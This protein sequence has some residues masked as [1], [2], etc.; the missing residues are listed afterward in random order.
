M[1][2]PMTV[3]LSVYSEH[4]YKEFVLPATQNAVTT[5]T[6]R[7]DVF[8]LPR[9]VNLLLEN[10]DGIWSFSPDN[11]IQLS[12]EG[13]NAIGQSLRG[14]QY[15]S[16]S[17]QGR[18]ALAILVSIS[19]QH[20]LSYEKYTLTGQN[21]TIGTEERCGLQ[22]SFSSQNHQYISGCHAAISRQGNTLSILD[23]S[24]NG[25][26]VNDIRIKGE[27]QLQFG[28]RIDVWGLSMVA[29]GQVLAVRPNENLHV[30]PSQLTLSEEEKAPAPSDTA[31][32]LSY[33]RS[34]RSGGH[35]IEGSIDLEAPP[36]PQ[37][38][39]EQPL[40]MVIGPALTMA[41]PMLIGSGMAVIGAG[42]SSAFMYTGIVTAVLSAVIGAMWALINLRYSR[43]QT[44]NAEAHRFSAYSDYL[45]R[46]TEKIR[47][48]YEQN[49]AI[50]RQTYPPAIQCLTQGIDHLW[51][52]NI[53]HADYLRYRLGLGDQPFQVEIKVPAER[54]DLIEDSLKTKP[55]MIRE[56]FKTLHDVPVCIDLREERI[57]GL[58]GGPDR[59]GA[60]EVLYTLVSQIVAQNCYTD[61][62]LAFSYHEDQGNDVKNWA[63]CRW[64]P[65]AWS[66]DRKSRYVA[67]NKS[68]ASDMFYE[69]MSILRLRD[70][71]DHTNPN[72]LPQKP[73]YI[74]IIEDST[75]LEN[76]P[77]AKYLLD[78]KHDYGITTLFL[79]DRAEDLPN[80]CECVISNSNGSFVMYH[81]R[82]SQEEAGR[83]R[84]DLVSREELERFARSLANIEV[85][86]IEI[87]GEIPSAVTFFDMYGIE[88]LEEL[89]VAERWKRSRTYE[90]MRALIGQKS[91][92][93]PCYLDIHEKYH[94]PH[95][96]VAGTTGS[97]KS[98]T[99]QTYILSLTLNFSPYD[100][101]LFIIDYKGGGMANLFDGLPHML[102]QISNLSGNQVHRAMVSIKSENLRRQRIFNESGVNNINLYTTLYKNGEAKVPVPHLFIIIDEFAELKREQPDFMRELISVAQVGRSL[103]VH[104]ILATQKPS[105]TVDDNIWSNSKFRL[106]LRVQDRQDSMD[107]L[108]KPDAAYLTQAGRGFLQVGSDEVY[109]QFQSGWSGAAYDEDASGSKQVLARMLSNT[110]KTALV[111]NY[112]KR[113]RKEQRLTV[114]LD[115]L[116]GCLNEVWLA[117]P[118]LQ[119][120]QSE[121]ST[122][123]D[124][125]YERFAAQG[126]SYND[127]EYNRRLLGNFVRLARASKNQPQQASWISLHAT[128][129]RI[130]LPE[131]KEKT[132]LDA[133]VGYLAEQAKTLNYQPLPPL[134]LD[135]LPTTLA[136]EELENWQINTFQNGKWP[137]PPQKWELSASVGLGDDPANQSQLPVEINFRQG[138]NDGLLGA[139]GTGKSTFVQTLVYSL[140]HRYTPEYLNI[141][142][143]DFSNHA[144]AAFEGEAHI[145]GILSE[146][147]LDRVGK[148]FYLLRQM[149]AER[150]KAFQGG[151][152]AQYVMVH[153]PQYPAV[154]VA[155]DGVANFRE[156]T[157]ERYDEELVRLAREG[158][159]F[160]IYFFITGASF[161]ITEIFSR[162]GDNLRTTLSLELSDIYQYGDALRCLQPSLTPEGGIPGRGL[163]EAGG[164]ILEYQTALAAKN[165][166]DYERVE[167]IRAECRML[168]AAW[169][170]PVARQVPF[171]PKNPVW[172]DLTSREDFAATLSDS[173]ALPLGY[174]AATAGIY[175]LDLSRI[176]CYT[177]AGR[178]RSGKTN[179]L[180]LLM[181]GAEAKGAKIAVLETGGTSL[182]GEA[183]LLNAC[184]Y[185]TL[186]EIVSFVGN[187]LAPTFKT[188][189]ALKLELATQG[190]EEEAQYQRMCQEQ[191]WL[192]V[193]S[194]LTSFLELV[195]SSAGRERNLN[196]ALEN[197]IGKGFLHQ[198]FFAASM[199]VD[200]RAR[201]ASE[202]VLY[203]IFTKG[204]NGIL[205][206]GS[207]SSQQVFDFSGMPFKEQGTQEKP[208]VGL[209]P[210]RNGEPHE[211]V[212]LPL[213]K[214]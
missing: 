14:T 44:K 81:T 22:Y 99:L 204:Q 94:G 34:P 158:A 212:I 72:A 51:E 115:R 20:L 172:T 162:L 4:A 117:Q 26:F 57:V 192:V 139:A 17:M 83:I 96:L 52:R 127:N 27:F 164:A 134:W 3:I 211:R 181:R 50:L 157:E 131:Q 156:K 132:Q 128:E 166:D 135:P 105:G 114:W 138:G 142:I 67:T 190:L 200:D 104:L 88:R 141:Y 43:K 130:K 32:K 116:L 173:K 63:F 66:E 76:E 143:L 68:E 6:I 23:K 177:V 97:G 191:T 85:N 145:G 30:D 159:G 89:H 106:C 49:A 163:I 154:V 161:G 98:E 112:I 155:I 102:G 207:A 37:Q 146:N 46:T 124:A 167:K 197:L 187:E 133:V 90:N 77:I 205:L 39:A 74:L 198:I 209:V 7:R 87:G 93:Q 194:D 8:G 184:Y 119:D 201:A 45:V 189:H 202:G 203:D 2:G 107:M 15:I 79:T 21:I 59:A 122:L 137:S 11:T 123:Y 41:L 16:C 1:C 29:L 69:L 153:G 182:Q 40:F 91:G 121:E 125:L 108:H 210:P 33:H 100:V 136:L 168:N 160:G 120:E 208:G 84:P 199:N 54:F 206:G 183:S 147:N 28:D 113:Q 213:A 19:E 144:C 75:I 118:D 101:G 80:A 165:E 196:G 10:N 65:H 186:D 110:G 170:G 195:Y 175:S 53:N 64:L 36:A 71:Q 176:Y 12:C 111:G 92:N 9:E 150:K 58:V 47:K 174:V 193:I 13:K 185:S 140:I 70:A 129:Q 25:V 78:T 152:Y 60:R 149:E 86:E 82:E 35:L 214:G 188:R 48:Q 169:E 55:S 171:I 126:I 38:L 62:K 151:N 148:L 180:R 31:A 18:N 5:V 24:R 73:W 56:N 42:S 103:G 61:V 109:E 179:V 95:G 178:Q